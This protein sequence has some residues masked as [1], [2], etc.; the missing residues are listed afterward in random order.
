MNLWEL[1]IDQDINK[2][3][4]IYAGKTGTSQIRTITA[5]KKENL[6]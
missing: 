2:P 3:E 1:L 5:M 6:N 4:Y